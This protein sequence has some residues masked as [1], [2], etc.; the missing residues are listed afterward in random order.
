MQAYTC[1]RIDQVPKAQR[2]GFV[3]QQCESD[4]A[5]PYQEWYYCRVAPHGAAGAFLFTVRGRAFVCS[6]AASRGR[7]GKSAHLHAAWRC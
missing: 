6:G 2:C 1:D 7:G 5:I 3:Q 4:S